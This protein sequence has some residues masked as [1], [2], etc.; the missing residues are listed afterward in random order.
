MELRGSSVPRPVQRKPTEE[1]QHGD[2]LTV[3]MNLIHKINEQRQE[4]TSSVD[5]VNQRPNANE[6]I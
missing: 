2:D 6:G 3:P 4:K 1:Q 5:G